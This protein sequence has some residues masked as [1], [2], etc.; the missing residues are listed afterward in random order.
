[1]TRLDTHCL[2]RMLDN[3][4]E[5]VVGKNDFKGILGNEI[6]QKATKSAWGEDN[7]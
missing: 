3:T 6:P 7:N 5:G 4:K 2:I 1:L